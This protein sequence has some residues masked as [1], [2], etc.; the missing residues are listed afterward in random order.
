MTIFI[1]GRFLTQPVSGV[2]RYAREILNALD[3]L[4][5]DQP[6]LLPTVE[7]VL[8]H[9]VDVPDWTALTTR[10]V[11][12]GHGHFWEQSS[13]WAATRNGILVSLGNSGPLAHKRHVLCLHDAHLYDMP[14]AFSRRY[15][16]WHGWLRPHLAKR[17]ARLITVSD[18]SARALSRHLSV[19]PTRFTVIP[20]SAEHLLR[21]PVSADAPARYGLVAGQYLLS[22]GNQSP[23]KN[24]ARLVQAHTAAGQDLPPLA[25]VGGSVPGVT[26]AE[27]GTGCVRHLGRVPDADLRGLYKGATGFVF[28]SLNEGFGIP[29]LEA[30]QLGV[31]VMCARSGAMPD[32]L[33]NAPLWFDPRDV[34]DMTRVLKHFTGLSATQRDLMR[35][36]GHAVVAR[37]S[38]TDSAT[39]LIETVRG[40]STPAPFALQTV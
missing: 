18:H 33:E 8:P 1:N 25:L 12:G 29:P 3:A 16:M 7:V 35:Q 38:W 34:G 19:D 21:G 6:H 20:N 11:R 30:M 9:T 37:Y 24:L 2:Q 5:T 40:L 31:P 17:S 39:A 10:I 22:V 13:L 27:I 26:Q 32:V 4:L 23:N 15:R 36:K 28:P 14:E